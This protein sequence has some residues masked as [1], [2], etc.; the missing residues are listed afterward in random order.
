MIHLLFGLAILAA[1][2]LRE[3]PMAVVFGVFLYLGICS[4]IGLDFVDRIYLIFYPPK[5]HPS[6]P[7]VQQVSKQTSK[8]TLFYKN[9]TLS[10]H[11][12]YLIQNNIVISLTI[13]TD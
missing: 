10:F 8:F 6:L 12:I 9:L 7:Y 4:L 5:H 13:K 2:V 1:P 11:I 3:I